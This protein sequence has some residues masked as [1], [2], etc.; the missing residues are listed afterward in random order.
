VPRPSPTLG[1][2]ARRFGPALRAR[3]GARLTRAQDR[4]L[5]ALARCRTPAAGGRLYRCD[6]CAADHLVPAGCRDRHCPSCLAHRSA[7]WLDARAADLLPVPYFHVVFTVPAPLAAL[8]LGNKKA[9]YALLFR[10]VS[11]TL[12]TVAR[13][14]R[15]LGADLGFLAILH[16]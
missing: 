14:D 6:R 10:A 5:R 16:T 1:D 4:V 12:L 3:R 15:H 11:E 7:D 9:V 8:A 13:D 2:V